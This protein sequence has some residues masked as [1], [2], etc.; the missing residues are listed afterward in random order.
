M[1]KK[2]LNDEILKD[3][4]TFMNG[5]FGVGKW[6]YDTSEELYIA[7]D[8]QYQGAEFGFVAISKS[9][10]WFNGIRPVADVVESIL[11]SAAKSIEAIGLYCVRSPLSMPQGTSFGLH[12][13]ESIQAAISAEVATRFGGEM[14]HASSSSATFSAAVAEA[15]A[16]SAINKAAYKPT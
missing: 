14:A 8:P 2:Q 12:V 1:N 10:A 13:A 6:F 16:D 7:R 11:N 15:L 3:L 4:P 9:G 5:L